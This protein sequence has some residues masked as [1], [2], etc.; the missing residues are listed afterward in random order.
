MWVRQSKRLVR[1]IEDSTS[2]SSSESEEPFEPE[3]SP[4][5]PA[6]M[7]EISQTQLDQLIANMSRMSA[8]LEQLG[9]KVKELDQG[10]SPDLIKKVEGLIHKATN[11]EEY[12]EAVT[13]ERF[14][15]KI[16]LPDKFS[17]SD[18]PKFQS[19]DNPDYH[20]RNF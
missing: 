15:E 2:T 3:N 17:A 9:A 6:T 20:L 5:I 8:N 1:N 10:Q 4:A 16:E 12:H 18:I 14:K 13:G 11:S 19:T 7:A